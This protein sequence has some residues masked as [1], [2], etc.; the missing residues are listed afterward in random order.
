MFNYDRFVALTSGGEAADAALKIARKWGCLSKGI[1][2]DQ[3]HILSTSS[4]YHG[5]GL[6]GLSLASKKSS[7][8]SFKSRP[9]QRT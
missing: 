5:V 6:S 1:P 9:R 4:C 8:E 3:C 7:R 2:A